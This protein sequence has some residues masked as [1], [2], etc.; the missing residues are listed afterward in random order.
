MSPIATWIKMA[1]SSNGLGIYRGATD[2]WRTRW[3]LLQPRRSTPRSQPGTTRQRRSRCCCH[4][5][6]R[7]EELLRR[8]S[9]RSSGPSVHCPRRKPHRNAEFIVN[10]N[11]HPAT[12]SRT[13]PVRAMAN[14]LAGQRHRRFA[15][16]ITPVERAGRVA[17]G[18]AAAV[19][20]VILLLSAGS[21]LA[22]VLEVLLA[23]AGLDLVVTGTLG[24]CPLYSRLGHVPAS[25][26]RSS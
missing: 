14:G 23:V 4:H 10:V 3:L 20:A 2:D 22:V 18:L 25:L 19:V 13:T 15:V 26:R 5:E 12:D 7:D 21:A 24:H 9:E 16:N 6:R 17:I 8:R 11:G 1:T